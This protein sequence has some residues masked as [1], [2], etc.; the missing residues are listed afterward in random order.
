MMRWSYLV[1]R[2]ILLSL[3]WA[4]FAFVFDP[5][6]RHAIRLAGETV[7][8]APVEVGDVTTSFFPPLL[9]VRHVSVANRFSPAQNMLE[10]DDLRLRLAGGP[11]M[12]RSFIVD[13]AEITGLRWGTNR[14]HQ[15]RTND[16]GDSSTAKPFDVLAENAAGIGDQVLSHL[17]NQAKAQLE[18]SQ[19]ESVRLADSLREQWTQR[20]QMLESRSEALKAKVQTIQQTVGMSKGNVLERFEA[21]NRAAAD[22]DNLLTEVRRLRGELADL[23][24]TARND[25]QAIHEAKQRDL[26]AI[27]DKLRLLQLDGQS[28]SEFLLGPE[29]AQRLDE[30]VTWIQCARELMAR[31][32]WEP[33]P[34]RERGTDILFPRKNAL[35]DFLIRSLYV[36]GQADVGGETLA[37]RGR[38]SGVSSD[39]EIYGQPVVVRIAG[40]GTARLQ[41]EASMD[42]TSQTPKDDVRF[43]YSLPVR[44]EISLG[45]SNSLQLF[46]SAESTEWQA[47]LRFEGDRLAGRLTLRQRPVTH[48]ARP[49]YRRSGCDHPRSSQER[50]DPARS[51]GS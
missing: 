32:S 15:G 49:A 42:R 35:P 5:L 8:G 47:R 10:F 26:E 12:K 4:L 30:A 43:T 21:Y 3:F 39:P 34:E 36:S 41:L 16:P 20:F 1:P 44:R 24:Q 40:N 45:A 17:L 23:S 50:C 31:A 33:K 7:A 18:P 38:V 28:L 2:M 13:Q 22:L 11:L 29:L 25:L 37:F 9:H 27:Q 51:S 19:L 14:E 6:L 48:R 46:V